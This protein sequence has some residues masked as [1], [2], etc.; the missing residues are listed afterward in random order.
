MRPAH[1]VV[2]MFF[3]EIAQH[4]CGCNRNEFAIKE[5]TMKASSKFIRSIMF[6]ALV[7]GTWSMASAQQNQDTQP[8]GTSA[9][10]S[11]DASGTLDR[12]DR[13]F[14]EKAAKDGMAEVELGRLA[15]SKA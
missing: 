2:G 12:K 9:A 14:M 7:A 10:K 11:S 5:A 1:P 15:Q 6:S 3:A 8:S 4:P 13:K